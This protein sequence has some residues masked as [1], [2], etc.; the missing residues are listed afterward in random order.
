MS[1]TLKVG[2]TIVGGRVWIAPM[3]GDCAAIAPQRR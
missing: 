2:E 1:K 3:T